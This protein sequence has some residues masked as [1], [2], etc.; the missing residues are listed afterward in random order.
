[1]VYRSAVAWWFYVIAF[2]L[3]VVC[4]YYAYR[5][6][7][8]DAG[9]AVYAVMGVG[10][11]TTTLHCGSSLPHTTESTKRFYRSGADRSSGA[12]RSKRL[13]RFGEVDRPCRHLLCR[14]TDCGFATVAGRES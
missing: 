8:V 5:L 9:V 13:S 10:V 11:M 14:W 3:P 4:L 2:G 12:S 1:M 7:G 6:I